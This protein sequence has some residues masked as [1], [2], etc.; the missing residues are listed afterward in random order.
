[1]VPLYSATPC[2]LRPLAGFVQS[3]VPF[4]KPMKLATPMGA[5]SGK[6]VQVSLPAVVSMIAVGGAGGVWVVAGFFAVVL[7][8]WCAGVWAASGRQAIR[9]KDAS[10]FC[11]DT[12]LGRDEVKRYCTT[13]EKRGWIGLS[14]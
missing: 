14:I 4:A 13:R 11:M 5:L 10:N 6:R 9:T 7:V 12:P 3:L 1:M 2:I 8:V